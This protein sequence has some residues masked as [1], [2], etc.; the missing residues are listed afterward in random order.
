MID[1]FT[2]TGAAVL[3]YTAAFSFMIIRKTMPAFFSIFAGFVFFTIFIISR[4]WQ[5]LIFIP[6][7]LF[8]GVFFMPWVMGLMLVTA[9]PAREKREN[10]ITGVIP[11]L[12]SAFFAAVYPKGIIPPTPNKLTAWANIFFVT[13]S[14]GHACFYFGAWFAFLSMVKKEEIPGYHKFIVWGFVLFSIS[15]VSG[16]VWAFLGWGTPFRWGARHLQSAVIWCYYAAY[17]HIRFLKT[18]SERR[19]MIYAAAGF[20]L[21]ILCTFGS[22]LREMT[23]P[24]VGG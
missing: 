19:R 21:V 8:E 14:I 18:W 10:T 7:G 1:V 20:V 6:N 2:L 15:Q 12:C 23:F 16:A 11:L 5:A 17:L 3:C 22:Y 9:M 4:G 13:E 24:R